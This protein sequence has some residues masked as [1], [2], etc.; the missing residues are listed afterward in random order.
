MRDF[1]EEVE[2]LKKDLAEFKAKIASM[3]TLIDCAVCCSMRLPLFSATEGVSLPDA[4]ITERANNDGI[5]R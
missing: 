4:Y 2:A 1:E 3:G 5:P